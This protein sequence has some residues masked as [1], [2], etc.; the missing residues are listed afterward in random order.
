M[1]LEEATTILHVTLSCTHM[2]ASMIFTPFV[3]IHEP[4]QY[5]S[6]IRRSL[7]TTPLLSFHY[8]FFQP[9]SPLPTSI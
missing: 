7:C 5:Q 1:L 4:S 3:S 2:L 6:Y 8:R 9:V